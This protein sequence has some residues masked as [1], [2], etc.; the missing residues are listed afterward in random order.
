MHYNLKLYVLF[1]LAFLYWFS[2][3]ASIKKL[4]GN[5]KF[6]FCTISYYFINQLF[7]FIFFYYLYNLLKPFN[8]DI[9]VL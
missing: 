7:I 2:S 1:W 4:L 6:L 8:L 3:K 9:L 5:G